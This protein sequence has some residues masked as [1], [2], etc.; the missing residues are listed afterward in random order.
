MTRLSLALIRVYR[1]TVGPL[2]AAFSNCRYQPTCSKYGYEAIQSFGPRRGW[3][4]AIRRI[5]R[6]SP[7]GGHGYDPVPQEY[8]SWRQARRLK[9]ERAVSASPG[10]AA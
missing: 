10:D 3:W 7:F 4:L 6:C 5:A 8:V 2:F 1:V 9:R